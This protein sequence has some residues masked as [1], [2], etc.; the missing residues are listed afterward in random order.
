MLLENKTAL[1]TGASRGIGRETALTLAGE[2][3]AVILLARGEAE[4]NKVKAEIETAGGKTDCVV[5]DLADENQ[6]KAASA[7]ILSK[8]GNIDI[9]INNAG[10]TREGAF[11]E[12]PEEDI[13][14]QMKVNVKAPM[15]L[16]RAFLPG[17]LE[18]ESG[19]IV[20]IASGTGVRGCPNA[21]GNAMSKAALINLSQSVGEEYRRR[22]IRI[23]AVSPGPVDTELF[24]D[25]ALHEYEMK[26]G[27]DVTKPSTVANTVLFLVSDMTRTI[28]CQ[29]VMVRGSSRW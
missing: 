17:M 24:R 6:V 25:S 14:I 16:M 19:C 12:M 21:A 29:N 1:I 22:G 13:D 9:L 10:I 7:E 26:R 5:C 3:A 27:G 15:L 4:L 28:A 20:N 2:G 23:N 8:Y 11:L 18:K